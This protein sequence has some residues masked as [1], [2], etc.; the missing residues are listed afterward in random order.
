V[1]KMFSIIK[2]ISVF[3]LFFAI[4]SPFLWFMS[5]LNQHGSWSFFKLPLLV[6]IIFLSLLVLI[7]TTMYLVMKMDEFGSKYMEENNIKSFLD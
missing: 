3:Y 1:R 6:Q 4:W 2:K 7:F 5:S